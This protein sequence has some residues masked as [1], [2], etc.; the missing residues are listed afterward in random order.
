M[1]KRLLLYVLWEKNGEV[2]DFVAYSLEQYRAF[3]GDVLV[4]ANGGLSARGRSRLESLGV[5]YIERENT[6]LDFAAWKAAIEQE[7]WEKL[8]GLDELILANC[9][10][11]GPFF[12]LQGVFGRMET[13]AC[14]FW[15]MTRHPDSANCVIPEEPATRIISH[16]Q[17]YF[18]VFRQSA[19]C[20]ACFRRWWETLV[21][22]ASYLEEV[23]YHEVQFTRYLE[24]GGL[25]AASYYE[26]ASSL[27]ENPTVFSDMEEVL[28]HQMP[29]IKVKMFSDFLPYY[30]WAGVS[31]FPWRFL[32]RLGEYT[33]YP[34]DNIWRNIADD[35]GYTSLPQPEL[36]WGNAAAVVQLACSGDRMKFLLEAP[37][38]K[39]VTASCGGETYEPCQVAGA[40]GGRQLL[41]FALPLA[42]NTWV[43]LRQAAEPLPLRMAAPWNMALRY[44]LLRRNRLKVLNR[45]AYMRALGLSPSAPAMWRLRH[46]VAHAP[47]NTMLFVETGIPNKA[48]RLLALS[49]A[50]LGARVRFMSQWSVQ[51]SLPRN[52]HAHVE[53][54]APGTFAKWA[55]RASLV[56]C[57]GVLPPCRVKECLYPMLRARVVLAYPQ[58]AELL[59]DAHKR[60]LRY[61]MPVEVFA[62]SSEEARWYGEFL[63]CPY[64]AAPPAGAAARLLMHGQQGATP[65]AQEAWR[66]LTEI[67]DAAQ[68]VGF[69]GTSHAGQ[70]PVEP[71]ALLVSHLLDYTGAP[72]ALLGLV[73]PLRR[74]GLAVVVLSPVDGPLRQAFEQK[75]CRVLIAPRPQ[76]I[77]PQCFRLMG[78]ELCICNTVVMGM[79]FAA[80]SSALPSLLWIH[81]NMTPP[82]TER[83]G[84]IPFTDDESM[85]GWESASYGVMNPRLLQA[86]Q[87]LQKR[88]AFCSELAGTPFRKLLPEASRMPYVIRNQA[89]ADEAA[90]PSPRG[91]DFVHFAFVGSFNRRKSPH[92]ILEALA[93]IPPALRR[94]CRISLV[95]RPA[96]PDEYALQLETQAAPFAEV[97][98]LPMMEPQ[99]VQRFY[100]TVD[101]LLCPSQS[102]P[103]PLV[104]TEAWMHG[105]PVVMTGN[106][107]QRSMAEAGDSRN[108]YVIPVGDAAALAA[109]MQHLAEHPEEL[110]LLSR[111]A[112]RTYCRYFDEE[113]AARRWMELAAQLRVQAVDMPAQPVVTA[114]DVQAAMPAAPLLVHLH[115]QR[116]CRYLPCYLPALAPYPYELVVT[117]PAGCTAERAR[118]AALCPQAVIVELPEGGT[119]CANPLSHV[120]QQ[121]ERSKYSLYISLNAETWEDAERSAALLRP[122]Y[123]AAVLSA[124]LNLP[125]LV[126][127]GHR[128]DVCLCEPGGAPAAQV[129]AAER[130]D[131]DHAL[132]GCLESAR[133]V[134]ICRAFLLASVAELTMP[135]TPPLQPPP[136]ACA[137]L[138]KWRRI[139][140]FLYQDK[141]T[142]KRHR[143]IKICKVPVYISKRKQ[144]D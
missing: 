29:L 6:G 52:L 60:L 5:R 67:S 83:D 136:K 49:A 144:Y 82:D 56:V 91:G 106:V 112:R 139:V 45:A 100:K 98:I 103:M 137:P 102:D 4:I 119:A 27:A 17:S 89:E 9:S 7:G 122:R 121:V 96:E 11:Y 114:E 79:C 117:L 104:V 47:Q 133:N 36:E 72:I 3:A 16:L 62:A 118:I 66:R 92:L 86:L 90:L 59:G 132:P 74:M 46:R 111:N 95:G 131:L 40:G 71:S 109:A 85:Y 37:S 63:A 124:F 128:A 33:A 30:Q 126:V 65:A 58:A 14:D 41:T 84:E 8:A 130:R 77:D 55:Y 142:A 50:A 141:T 20:S 13:D 70:P 87:P 32:E 73:E 116:G 140:R 57:D 101:V 44:M 80:Y 120:L 1:K 115:G 54:Y 24:Q 19:I 75:G 129:V 134:F 105:C 110:P 39:A 42:V 25:R 68:V 64:Q 123:L 135:D 61:Q 10:C 78:V 22:A 138:S 51:E 21:P 26:D 35:M 28:E 18:L 15:G 99:D 12:P 107:G 125:A 88:V 69:H 93:M 127:V 48:L 94:R 97:Q 34:M 2:R 81:E 76:D 143:I 53:E 108:A 38:G 31:G 23:G 113:N 43:E